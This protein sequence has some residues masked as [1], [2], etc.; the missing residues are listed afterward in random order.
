MNYTSFFDSVVCVGP[1]SVQPTGSTVSRDLF[2]STLPAIAALTREGGSFH[3]CGV[4]V[5]HHDVV[6]MVLRPW[7]CETT[8][9]SDKGMTML[10]MITAGNGAVL[11]EPR[12]ST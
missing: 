10:A 8:P 9:P 6:I 7:C 2:S 12:S 5:Q 1:Q 4:G 3:R 11:S